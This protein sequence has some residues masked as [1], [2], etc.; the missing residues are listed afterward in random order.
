MALGVFVTDI[1]NLSG[2]VWSIAEIL[3]GDFKQSEYGKVILP[4]VVLRRLDCILD[5]TKDAVLDAAKTLPDGVDDA[6]RDMILF[7]AV[8]G[9]TQVYNLSRF[10]FDKLRGQDPR[11]LHDNLV[12]YITQFSGNVRD[13]FLDKFLFTEQLKRLK[14]GGILWNVFERFCAIDLHPDTISNLEMGYL[15]EELIRRFSEISNET[16]GE[17]FTPR[18]VIRLIVDLLI[19]ND[20]E[21]LTGRGII[22]QVYDPACGTGGMLALTEEALKDFNDAIRVELFGQELNGESFGICKSDML[23]TGHDPEQI[24][25]GNTLTQDAHKDKKFHYMLS[26][27]PYGVDWKKYQDPIKAEAEN[28]GMDGRFGAG[29]PRISDGQ[30]LFLQHMISKM[31]D[32]EIGSRIGIV[33]NGSPLFTGG[34]GSGESEIR[35][36]MLE[37]DWVEAIVA[38]PTDLFYNTGIQTYVWL[39]TNRKPAHRQG[40]VQLIDASGERFWKSM[41]KSLGSK[42]R[43]ITDEARA[44][45]VRIYA[46]FLNGESGEGEVSRIFDTAD[47]GYREIR[48]E[49]PLKLNFQVSPE[50]LARLADQKPYARQP[51]ADQAAIEAALQAIGDQLFTNRDTFEKALAKALKAKGLKIGAPIKKAI[52]AALSERDD[53]ADICMGTDG[54][55]EADTDLRDHELVPLSED[56]RDY[57]KREVLPFVPDAWVDESHRDASDKQVGRVGYEINFNRYFY[58]YVPPRPLEEID[59]ELKALEAE[60]AGLLREVAA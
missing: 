10:T 26:N 60:I 38:L 52:L 47:F 54:K 40:K 39:L 7:G 28:L 3:R 36:W 59:A 15:F 12:D 50:R 31:R 9:N 19:A 41:R 43:E 18:E 4:F 16:A 49:R 46:G 30:L 13:I 55:P 11:Q 42:R 22:R 2:F 27:P 45:I 24:A 1:K 5:G 48:V 14:D 23:V 37:N 35:R 57:M 21:K 17:H 32:D 34:A 51:D 53:D 8:G 58:Q 6:T 25:F 33:M 56:W 20:D 29:T 44:E